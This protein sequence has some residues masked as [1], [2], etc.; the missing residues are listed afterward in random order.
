MEGKVIHG[1]ALTTD[2]LKGNIRQEA[3]AIPADMS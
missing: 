1:Y 2:D 3:A